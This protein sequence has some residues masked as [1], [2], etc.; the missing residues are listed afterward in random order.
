ML[1]SPSLGTARL[2]TR[3]APQ[4]PAGAALGCRARL[5]PAQAAPPPATP[6]RP[7][8]PAHPVPS[9]S[10]PGTFVCRPEAQAGHL[11]LPAWR[12]CAESG[13]REQEAQQGGAE[14]P[15]L[16]RAAR[17]GAGLG[18]CPGAGRDG[19]EGTVGV[20]SAAAERRA[21]RAPPGAAGRRDGMEPGGPGTELRGPAGE[22][23]LRPGRP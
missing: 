23:E 12:S 5:G 1:H 2:P 6:D 18:R 16:Y 13:A 10:A 4:E 21:V 22:G 20:R 17:P 19:A 9:H 14:Q 3:L 15:C 7:T 11:R 8:E